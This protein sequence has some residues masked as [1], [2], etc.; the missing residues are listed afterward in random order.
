[1]KTSLLYALVP[2]L[3]MSLTGCNDP[4]SNAGA[5]ASPEDASAMDLEDPCPSLVGSWELVSIEEDSPAL[6]G[7]FESDPNYQVAPTLKILNDTH[8]MFI[9]QSADNFIHAQGGRYT[10]HDG[11]YTEMVEYSAIP[12]NVGLDFTFECRLEGDSLWYHTGGLGDH[13]YQEVWRRVR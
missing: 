5:T 11:I 1:M 6:T 4:S 7:E 8:W 9:R 2:L 3:L 12:G 10:L 13:R